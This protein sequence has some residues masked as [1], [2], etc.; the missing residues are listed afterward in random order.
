M[1]FYVYSHRRG[2]IRVS[3]GGS[4]K[5]WTVCIKSQ[6]DINGGSK[7]GG[8]GGE[9]WEVGG[10]D[11]LSLSFLESPTFCQTSFWVVSGE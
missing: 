5:V 8:G 7:I 1:E 10:G 6:T 9:R 4:P 11:C 2:G 3:G